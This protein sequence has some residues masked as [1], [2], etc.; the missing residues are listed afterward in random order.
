MKPKQIAAGADVLD[1]VFARRNKA[2]GAYQ[3]RREYPEYIGRALGI[4]FLLICFFIASSHVLSRVSRAKALAGDGTEAVICNCPPPDA[5][6]PKPLPPIPKT[7]PPLQ[8]RS[9]VKFVPPVVLVDHA[10]PEPEPLLPVDE[11]NRLKMDIG[12]SNHKAD[13]E[14]P[15]TLGAGA[16]QSGAVLEHPAPNED[17]TVYNPGGVQK[18]PGFPGGEKELFLFL[19]RNIKYPVLAQETGIEGQVVLS[20]VV[21]KDGSI[22]NVTPMRELG[23]GCTKEAVRVVQ[24]MPRWIPGEANG[25]PVKVRFYLPVRFELQ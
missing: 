20:F 25:N 23:G 15:P 11:L 19:A 9:T 16:G 13:V 1:I 5:A 24:S 14:G 4:A 7:P 21:D 3:L 6:E 2:Y 12:A 8:T 10:V 17:D 22:T 18:M